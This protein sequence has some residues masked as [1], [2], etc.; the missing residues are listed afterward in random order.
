M[1]ATTHT[2][3]T[4][5]ARPP[6]SVLAL[7]A[8][9]V[10]AV[11][12]VGVVAAGL[13][14]RGDGGRWFV[15]STPS[16]GT[17]MPIGTLVLTSPVDVDDVRVGDVVTYRAPQSGSV[18]THRVVERVAGGG[19][20]V[21]LLTQGDLN[22]APDPGSIG[23]AD[24]VGRVAWHAPGLGWVLR[25][26]PV[27]AAGGAATW[28]ASLVLPLRRR[29]GARLVGASLTLAVANWLL[30]PWVG[31]QKVAQ[32]DPARGDGA[33]LDVVSVGLLPVRVEQVGGGA[34]VRLDDGELVT[35]RLA[36]RRNGS[37]TV[38]AVLDLPWWG[39]ALLVAVCLV[40]LAVSLVLGPRR[41][42]VPA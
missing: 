16:M 19:G 36:E 39:W 2:D 18:Y 14:W 9:L 30:H 34:S 22:A 10:V 35:M 40:P 7:G 21:R 38:A 4:A 33:L 3:G 8:V 29:L 12:V 37:Y 28:L 13:W 5:A 23:A 41:E 6:G 11:A 32:R 25:A 17:A 15:V 24:L 31:L 1:D 26:V 42:P 20:A 27:L